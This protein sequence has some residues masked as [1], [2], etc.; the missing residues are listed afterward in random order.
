MAEEEQLVA[1]AASDRV[2]DERPDRLLLRHGPKVRVQVQDG[3][4]RAGVQLGGPRALS[5]GDVPQP[6]QELLGVRP[7]QSKLLQTLQGRP[8]GRLL[9]LQHESRRPV[10]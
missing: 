1:M 5:R 4:R 6:G 2:R 10:P 8:P 3:V 7:G 9:L